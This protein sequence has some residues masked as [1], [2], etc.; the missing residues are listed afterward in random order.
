MTFIY[1]LLAVLAVV[2]LWGVS[3]YNFFV[4]SK[5]RIKASVQE[6]GNQLKR[7]ADLIPN[8]EASAKGYMKHEKGIFRDLTE[9]RMAVTNAI[10]SGDVQKMA[11]AGSRVASLVPQLQVLVESNPQLQAAGVVTGLMDELRDTAD[12]VMYARRLL[13]DLTADYNVKLATFPSSIVANMFGFTEQAG[14][15]TPDDGEAT[16]VSSSEMK[17]PK[18]DLS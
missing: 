6:I 10:K 14:L 1:V 9:A 12:K 18:V 4:S 13:I 8:L 2:L 3:V 16:S 15:V 11:D 7:Q 17:T 5:A